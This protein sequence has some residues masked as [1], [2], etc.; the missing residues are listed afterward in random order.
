MN[1]NWKNKML[2]LAVAVGMTACA[3]PSTQ[4]GKSAQTGATL[5]AFTS[6]ILGGDTE[7]IIVSAAVGGVGGALVGGA[8]AQEQ[9]AIKANVIAKSESQQK[10]RIEQERLELD[11]VQ[12]RSEDKMKLRTTMTAN[13]ALLDDVPLLERAYGKDNVDGILALRDCHHIKARVY[14]SAAENSSVASAKLASVW[15][16]ALIAVDEHNDAKAQ[17]AFERLIELD[18]DVSNSRQAKDFANDTMA[19]IRADRRSLSISCVI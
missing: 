1:A 8:K 14:A 4:V 9:E 16:K 7:D 17:L 5:G 2:L 19:D 11:K 18:P 10:L 15:L 6:L 13:N 3:S 12:Q